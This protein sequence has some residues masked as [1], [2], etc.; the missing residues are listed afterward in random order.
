MNV[1]LPLPI[2]VEPAL[3][4]VIIVKLEAPNAPC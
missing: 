4:D 3:L 1:G 2:V